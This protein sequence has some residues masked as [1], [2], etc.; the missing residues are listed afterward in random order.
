M[1]IPLFKLFSLMIRITSRPISRMMTL[2]LR[3]QRLS[4]NI[5]AYMGLKAHEFEA[6]LDYKAANPDIKVKRGMYEI[7]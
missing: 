1:G 2:L 5:F 7:K 3:K 4:F 6:Y